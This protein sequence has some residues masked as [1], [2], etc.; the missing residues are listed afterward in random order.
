[1]KLT[2]NPEYDKLVPNLSKVDY[3]NLKKSIEENGLWIPILCNPEGEILDGHNRYDICQEL[4]IKT[5]HAIRTFDNKTDEIIFVGECNLKRRHLEP[6]QRIELVRNLEP[7]YTEKAEQRM[8]S[9][10]KYF[11]NSNI[12][13]GN[14]LYCKGCY[15]DQSVIVGDGIWQCD[16]CGYGI[17]I[18]DD[19]PVTLP[20][21]KGDS[22][23]QLGAKSGVSGKT[24]EKGIKILDYGTEEQKDQVRTN[25]KTI[26][27][28]YNQIVDAERVETQE[29]IE[30]P[31]DKFQII[32]TDPPWKYWAGG[33]KNAARHYSCMGA[34]DLQSMNVNDIAADD[35]VIIMWATFPT[36]P[37]ALE[38]LK[39]WGFN[40]STVVFTWVKKNKSGDGWFFGTGNYTRANAEICLL[41]VK[42]KGLT[43][44][45]RSVRQICD[46]PVGEH[47]VKPDEI[48]DRIVELFGDVKRIEMFARKTTPG[49]EIWGNEV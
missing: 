1:M 10:K 24:Y 39:V 9:G 29:T 45:S 42:G 30:L 22:R 25:T 34:D 21:G 37:E 15:K 11:D 47:S 32:Y 43:V 33:M 12:K 18:I 8:K 35:S 6:F 27:S 38:L 17:A 36:L 26:S 23:D 2:I 48:R 40:Y 16:V 19:P 14:K 49:W 46:A 28:V 41:G 31:T 20:E 13:S 5:K 4:G 3:D 44:K 7:Y